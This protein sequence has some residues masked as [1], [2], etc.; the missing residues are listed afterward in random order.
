MVSLETIAT[1]L[2]LANGYYVQLIAQQIAD[3]TRC[4]QSVVTPKITC[5]NR[6]IRA[7]T[8][9]VN[10]E[11]NNTT[12]Q[13]LYIL[14]LKQI[15]PYTGSS[16][17]IDPNVVIPGSTVIVEQS[18]VTPVK[19]FFNNNAAPGVADW[20]ADYAESFGNDPTLAL[21]LYNGTPGS[22]TEQTG[23]VPTLQFTD[24]DTLLQ[25]FAF[26]FGFPQTGYILIST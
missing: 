22:Y 21:Y 17:P 26:D 6:L 16:L 9:D 24:S 3:F 25:S 20:Q 15:A 19:L 4:G 13:E 7:L 1:E 10:D 14:L 23:Q 5:L 8:W 12:T 18:Y 2:A 11:V